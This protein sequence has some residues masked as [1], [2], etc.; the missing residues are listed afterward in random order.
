VAYEVGHFQ[1]F[2]EM[3]A[4]LASTAIQKN[5]SR[6]RAFRKDVE[7]MARDCFCLA[8]RSQ[9]R[10]ASAR[11]IVSRAMRRTPR[12]ALLALLLAA[13]TPAQR[14][15][16]TEQLIEARLSS[17]PHPPGDAPDVIVH[18]PSHFD[19]S[20]PFDVVVFLHGF[21]SCARAIVASGAAACSA[22]G[23]VQR[24]YGLAAAHERAHTNTLLVVPQLAFLAR[25]AD[26]P[27]FA[28]AGG[29]DA[30]LTELLRGPLR[31]VS[32]AERTIEQLH[33]VT[34]IAHSA[35]YR[36]SADI[37]SDARRRANVTQLV[38]LDALYACWDLFADWARA[39]RSRRIVSLFTHDPKTTLGNRR[40]ASALGSRIE[41]RDF[42]QLE[43]RLARA[44][45]VSTR[46][47]AP[48]A[49]LPERY[50]EALLRRLFPPG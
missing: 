15:A 46:V 12:L 25:R 35:G 1:Q 27:R 17:P 2:C 31:E 13:S 14:A 44:G 34:L 49:L 50:L 11:A 26:A 33:G 42:A 19:A 36:A 30:M 40:L 6:R 23:E 41:V 3:R 37:L 9:L 20:H 45:S 38:L 24:G 28:R 16:A 47:S 18:V 7:S 48:H 22:G 8:A 29:F 21:S 32:G 4:L 39:E 5:A 10:L 43:Q